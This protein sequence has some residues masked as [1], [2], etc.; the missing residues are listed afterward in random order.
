[1]VKIQLQTEID[2]ILQINGIGISIFENGE[3]SLLSYS[4]DLVHLIVQMLTL[5]ECF[6]ELGVGFHLK[7]AGSMRIMMLD[8][9]S[10]PSFF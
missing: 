5:M 8:S 4:L 1:M 6:L 10:Y 7:F 9:F 2:N 3:S